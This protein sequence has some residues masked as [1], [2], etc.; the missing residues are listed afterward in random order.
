MGTIRRFVERAGS[1]H[2]P[3]V[4]VVQLGVFA[5]SGVA[6][7]LLRFDFDLPHRYLPYLAYALPIWIVVKIVVFRAAGLDRGWW[8]YVSIDDLRRILV[9]NFTACPVLK[10]GPIEDL[11]S[12]EQQTGMVCE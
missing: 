1:L 6:A 12:F 2:R 7:F 8:R 11:K 4:Q 3:M 5:F 10:A 9:G